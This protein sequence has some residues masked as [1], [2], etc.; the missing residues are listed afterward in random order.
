MNEKFYNAGVAVAAATH[1][2]AFNTAEFTK[3]A[4]HNT[5]D[6]TTSF[7]AGFKAEW[8]RRQSLRNPAPAPVVTA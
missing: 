8:K 7:G 5:K 1:T 2:A 3:A 4:A 6:A